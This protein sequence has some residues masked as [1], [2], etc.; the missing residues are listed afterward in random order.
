MQF[1]VYPFKRGKKYR[2]YVRFEDQHGQTKTL[3][4]GVSYPLRTNK[5][6]REKAF[7]KAQEQAIEIV[8]TNFNGGVDPRIDPTP[9]LSKYLEE[10]YFKHIK[11]DLSESSIRI[12]TNALHNFVRICGDRRVNDYKRSDI[13][14]YKLYRMENEGIKKTTINIELRSIKAGFNWGLKNEYIERHP[15]K[16]QD[17]MFEVKEKRSEFTDEQIERLFQVT[18]GKSIGLVVRFAYYT[19]LRIGS[20]SAMKW[21]MIDL[22]NKS[23]NLPKSIMKAEKPLFYPLGDKAFNIIQV[24][25]AQLKKKR[26]EH[27]EW[28]EDIPFSE[29]HV[30]Q[31]QNESGRYSIRGIQDMFR[32]AM[33]K[34]KLPDSL[35]FHCLRH[36]F[37]THTLKKGGSLNGVSKLLGHSEIAI[38]SK[39]YDHTSTLHYREDANLL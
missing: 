25:K 11:L 17:Y 13:Q 39:F 2:L 22:E 12:Y 21:K 4:T 29:C 30:F 23:L 33:D 19:G 9:L 31:K 7:K 28:Y 37:A 1:N 34:A 6:D 14:D 16:S 8:M 15:F 10:K 38:T 27:P 3:S 5:K 18:E 26:K 20:I 35:V 36:T 24:C 32:T